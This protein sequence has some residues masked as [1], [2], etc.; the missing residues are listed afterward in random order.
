MVLDVVGDDRETSKE[1]RVLC[2]MVCELSSQQ[3]QEDSKFEASLGYMVRP[4]LKP[5]NNNLNR[6]T[7]KSRVE[8]RPQRS[9]RDFQMQLLFSK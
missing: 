8:E 4:C 5:N 2:V 3:R 6:T 9:H 7:N 1:P